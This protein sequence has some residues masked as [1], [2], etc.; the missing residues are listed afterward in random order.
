[1]CSTRVT[2]C[3]PLCV[4]LSGENQ[5]FPNH[6]TPS[7]T[8]LISEDWNFGVYLLGKLPNGTATKLTT[9][10]LQTPDC[11]TLKSVYSVGCLALKISNFRLC[12]HE[13]HSLQV[14]R[15]LILSTYIF[16]TR[17]MYPQLN[18]LVSSLLG[19]SPSS[20]SSS[21][22]TTSTHISPVFFRITTTQPYSP[23]LYI[24]V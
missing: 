12:L 8:Y 3:Q 5:N 1:M 19:L 4:A 21:H 2:P 6:D 22:Q 16:P 18:R 20:A 13:L 9:L 14:G 10:T 15:Y 17:Y 24:H 7:K 23:W 11:L